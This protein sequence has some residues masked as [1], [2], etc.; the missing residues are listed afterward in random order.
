[1]EVEVK[2]R[3]GKRAQRHAPNANDSRVYKEI[4]GQVAGRVACAIRCELVHSLEGLQTVS[5]RCY[6]VSM[7]AELSC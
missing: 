1:M 2:D 6:V 5:A 7:G 3:L 4:R